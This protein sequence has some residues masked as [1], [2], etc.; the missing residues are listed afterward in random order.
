MTAAALAAHP[1]LA[2]VDAALAVVH[3]RRGSTA[4][5][6]PGLVVPDPATWVPAS[7]LV[8]GERLDPMLDAA[9]QRWSATLHV[10][11][12]LAWRSYTY[13]LAMPAV[14]GWATA[15]R[16]PVVT[17]DNVLVHF[18][19]HEPFLTVGLRRPALAVLPSD[20][21]AGS[22]GVTVAA[23]EQGLRDTL[24][25]MLREEH[26]D[27][28]LAQIQQRARLGD[29]TLLGS[30]ASA[31]AYAAVRGLDRTPD[32]V[33]AVAQTLLAELGVAD[34]VT[35][36]PGADGQPGVQRH[37]CCLAFTLPEP[38]VC[39]GCCLRVSAEHFART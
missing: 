31:V 6:W 28:L 33:V 12:A 30:L 32:E 14:L 8:S 37:T 36:A 11:A 17:P 38:K 10:A 35:V 34:L 27:P 5:L 15:R 4:G 13:W 24:R 19:A 16:V 25:R 23:D 26:L 9:K 39:S 1:A 18:A 21:L 3:R 29:R 20:P 7:A 2:P 22:P